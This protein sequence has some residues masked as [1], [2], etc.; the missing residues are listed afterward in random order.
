MKSSAFAA[1]VLDWED[2]QRKADQIKALIVEETLKEQKS[3]KIG[4]VKVTYTKG[5]TTY[6]YETPTKNFGSKFLDDYVSVV[7]DYRKACIDNKLEPIIVSVGEP[8][9]SIKLV[10]DENN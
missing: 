7:Y 3:Q 10:E 2:A 1:L 5:R 9:V 8:S 4:N 6:D